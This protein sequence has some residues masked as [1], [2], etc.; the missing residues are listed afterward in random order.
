MPTIRKKDSITIRPIRL[1]MAT[2]TNGDLLDL[3]ALGHLQMQ[4]PAKDGG[5]L[6]GRVALIVAR[7]KKHRFGE[8]NTHRNPTPGRHSFLMGQRREGGLR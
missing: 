7:E 5:F 2:K 4:L 3:D 8:S 6:C 1:S